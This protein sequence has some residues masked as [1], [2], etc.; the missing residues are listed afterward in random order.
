M[1]DRNLW[2]DLVTVDDK[3]SGEDVEVTKVMGKSENQHFT[4]FNLSHYGMSEDNLS[5][6]NRLPQWCH[7]GQSDHMTEPMEINVTGK[8]PE[9]INGSLYRNGAGLFKIG[10]N[11]WNHLFDG[12]AVLQRFTFHKGKI[13]YQASILD[14]SNYK[15]SAKHNRLVG[16][17][18]GCSFP[19]P[20][21]TIFWRFFNRFVPI[22]PKQI[23]NTNVNLVEF[24][25]HLFALTESS[26]INEIKPD[27]LSVKEKTDAR[28]VLAV[29]L[30]TAHP[31]KLK[32]GSMI[33]YGTNMK[34]KLAYNFIMV[35]PPSD[36][37][38]KPL[39]NAKIVASVPSRWKMNISYTHS[40][41]ITENYF[42]HVEQPLTINIPRAVFKKQLG[43]N[44]VDMII[45]HQGESMNIMLVDRSTGQR[46]PVTY[47]APEGVVFHFINCY[48]EAN[49]V[50][51]DLC[52]HP[53]GAAAVK[54]AYLSLLTE[55]AGSKETN[56]MHFARFV[57]PVL[58]DGAEA[59]KNLVTLPNTTATA[60][61]EEGSQLVLSL[62]PEII[63]ED[64][65]AELPQIN[66]NYNGV[67]HRYCYTS[68]AF[69]TA[70]RK[71]AK[72]DLV[73]KKVL[74]H[75]VSENHQPGEPVFLARPGT[76]QEDDGVVVSTIIACNSSVPS[77][78]VLLDASTFKEIGRASLPS[79]MKMSYTFHGIFT[80]KSL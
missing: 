1:A 21:E 30:G 10:P 20:C 58:C 24:G 16:P 31:H 59:G 44:A 3:Q 69:A 49:H 27:S 78:L 77:Y 62:T 41:G 73:E 13:T 35:P 72:F 79:E 70:Q 48:E 36:P 57:L 60:M 32:D 55:S 64:L 2:E 75:E 40:F 56:K 45:P 68:T 26:L 5:A 22:P 9:W 54:N 67:K 47:K 50:V 43:L 28:D 6:Y 63:E 65:V 4:T 17:G 53:K 71:L 11:A 76:T 42:V 39:A 80:D 14:S 8:I 25:D 34:F 12:Y 61:L 19:D 46:H 29:H 18:F 37:S 52:F 23:D 66:Y 7:F 15:R 74:V 33:Y 51:C 38:N